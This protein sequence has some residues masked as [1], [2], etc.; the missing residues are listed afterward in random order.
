M[1]YIICLTCLDEATSE[2]RQYL[3]EI[4]TVPSKNVEITKFFLRQIAFLYILIIWDYLKLCQ[5]LFAP[6]LRALNQISAGG[7]QQKI[8]KVVY[9]AGNMVKIHD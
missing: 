5:V 1:L 7:L 2:R 6:R 9:R 3:E 4:R 8:F